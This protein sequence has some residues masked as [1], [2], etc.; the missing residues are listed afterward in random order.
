M[1]ASKVPAQPE[2]KHTVSLWVN[3]GGQ[4]TS[5]RGGMSDLA[6]G[7]RIVGYGLMALAVAIIVSTAL[8][9][10]YWNGQ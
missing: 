1:T 8:V 6:Q 7:I 4:A 5:F 9:V 3:G 10:T 2:Q